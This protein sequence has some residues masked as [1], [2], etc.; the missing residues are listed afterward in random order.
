MPKLGS[1]GRYHAANSPI[2]RLDPRIKLVMALIYMVSCLFV[3]SA[4]T[5]ALAGV[6]VCLAARAS[7]IPIS[8][9]FAQLKTF[10]LLLALTSVINLFFVHSGTLIV[11]AGPVALYTGGIAAA[12]LYTLRFLFLL[13]AGSLLA[14]TT[15]AL[16]LADAAGRL[17]APLERIG[18]PVGQAMLILSIALRFAPTLSR[19]ANNI[20]AA[21]TA[22]GAGLEQMRGLAYLRACIPLA[23][24]LFASAP[25]PRR[26]PRPR[27][28]RPLPHRRRAHALPRHAAEPAPRCARRAR[29]RRLPRRFSPSAR[30]GPVTP[31]G[32][33]RAPEPAERAVTARSRRSSPRVPD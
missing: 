5:L 8:S 6:A 16:T 3:N 13:A 15:T 9:L 20:L 18:V 29:P 17:L 30:S 1:I 10:A 33:A 2:H 32:Y 12:A 14:L 25:A 31:G 22:R 11:A 24:P 23:V 21:Q 28:G 19:E 27:H 4:A 7:R 26:Q